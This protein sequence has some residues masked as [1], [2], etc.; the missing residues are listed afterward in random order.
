MPPATPPPP[1]IID[2]P[3]VFRLPLSIVWSLSSLFCCGGFATPF[4]IGHAAVRLRSRNLGYAAAGYG[5]TLI[6]CVAVIGHLDD[7]NP[8]TPDPP[9]VTAAAA[10][11]IIVLMLGGTIHALLL[12]SSV[13]QPAW[14]TPYAGQAAWQPPPAPATVPQPAPSP[15][16]PPP[17]RN[18]G[19]PQPSNLGSFGQY[20]LIRKLGEGGQGVVYLGQGPDGRSVAVKM[21]RDVVAG[22][23]GAQRRFLQ[24]VSNARRVP[25]YS[26]ARILDA[27]VLGNQA[28]I[29][30][31]YVP[32]PSLERLVTDGR[33][34]DEDALT[35]LAIATAAALK[36][37]HAAGVVHRDFKPANILI[38]ADG[39]RV[40]DFGI[41]R[42]L[43]HMT[44]TTGG[45]RGTPPY[46]SPEQFLDAPVGPASDIFSWAS[47]IF[48]GATGRLAF[49]GSMLPQIVNK[50]VS[51]QP[52]L[53]AVPASLRA[54]LA[55][56]FEKDPA[57]RPTAADLM[58]L[59]TH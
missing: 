49:D 38:G 45:L 39:P 4:I 19:P 14:A 33:P 13:F 24:E 9:A 28:Y 46:M 23:D 12:R 50:I 57:K 16:P 3:S 51:S 59:L 54:P 20:V 2:R 30:S 22:G 40:I 36:G 43:D 35:R 15:P 1:R 5:A 27:G 29:V 55:A 52:D 56:C 48:F 42:A 17:A 7:Q 10:I 21:L 37:I 31:E 34:L 32:G 11:W 26:T 53:M 41:A 18:P 44:L 8:A 6:C 58:L 47:S 25:G